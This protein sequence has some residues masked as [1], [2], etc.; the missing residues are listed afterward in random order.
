ME[1]YN[2]MVERHKRRWIGNFKTDG[3][4]QLDEG[5]NN[6]N[7]LIDNMLAPTVYN[8]E[9]TERNE[10]NI[11]YLINDRILVSDVSRTDNDTFDKKLFSFKLD[12][13]VACGCY[14]K[15][16]NEWWL[17][18]NEE[19]NSFQ[20]H[21][22]YVAQKCNVIINLEYD[23]GVYS[24]P[25][26]VSNLTLYSDG[27]AENVNMTLQDSKRK[28]SIAK[29]EITENRLTIGTRIMM[30]RSTIFRVTLVDD[31]TTEGVYE[32]T[33]LQDI[34]NDRDDIEGNIA[35]NEVY[36][37]E[38]IDLPF[39]IVGD[40]VIYLGDT[41][42]YCCLGATSWNIISVDN[43]LSI[44]YEN[45]KCSITCSSDN[46]YANTSATLI[47]NGKIRKNIEIRGVF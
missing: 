29:N 19:N 45:E 16:S 9:R 30:N 42:E 26:V 33:I 10:T 31:F 22:T 12:S 27:L 40:D 3:E 46:K 5:I 21:K 6:F 47:V 44:E 34:F 43:C 39:D 13:S 37:E 36:K 25:T 23:D 2:S 38:E 11:E 41:A 24:Y 15:W 18:C 35:W 14:V 1:N 28:F 20:T 8:I 4:T 7:N 32:V 17:L